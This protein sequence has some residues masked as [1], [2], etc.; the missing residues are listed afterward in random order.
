M[1]AMGAQGYLKQYYS[2][3]AEHR[4]NHARRISGRKR[5]PLRRG[6]PARDPRRGRRA[7]TDYATFARAR[8]RHR[9]RGRRPHGIIDIPLTQVV[10][11]SRVA[12]PARIALCAAG[13]NTMVHAV[14]R[15]REARRHPRADEHR[16]R[17]GRAHRRAAGD[18]G[19]GARRRG[20]PRRR[21]RARPRRARG[22]RPADLGA[23]RARAGR[24]EGRGRGSS[25]CRSSSAAPRSGRAT[26]S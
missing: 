24:D 15:A 25:T 6:V 7:V 19:A 5:H 1:E 12:G 17:A 3:R 18:A 16:A 22:D 13:D 11:G 4:A 8:R 10:P 20:D 9:A 26:S 14:D 2:E 23:V 21:R